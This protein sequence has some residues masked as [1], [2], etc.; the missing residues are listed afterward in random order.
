MHLANLHQSLVPRLFLCAVFLHGEEP[1]HK[2][3]SEVHF[4]KSALLKMHDPALLHAW[5]RNQTIFTSDSVLE[6]GLRQK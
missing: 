6:L 5:Y 1:G 4:C 3:K 2:A